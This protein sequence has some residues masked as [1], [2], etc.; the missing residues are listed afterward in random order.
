MT[1]TIDI[2][3]VKNSV[4]AMIALTSYGDEIVLEENGEPVVKVTPTLKPEKKP[5]TPCLGKGYW[6]SDDFNDDLPDE[7]W[8]F[9][10][11]L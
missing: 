4:Q 2:K 1:K 8:G 11:E 3:Q 7:F 5:R 9:D 10:K 6:M